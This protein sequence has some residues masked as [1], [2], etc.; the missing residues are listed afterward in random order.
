MATIYSENAVFSM[1]ALIL[2]NEEYKKKIQEIIDGTADKMMD[3]ET[4]L[5]ETIYGNK[6]IQASVVTPD[7]AKIAR[8]NVRDL[9]HRIKENNVMIRRLVASQPLYEGSPE[10]VVAIREWLGF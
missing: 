6:I 1:S 2:K 10:E 5:I 8:D 4:H 3:Y 9:A 7:V